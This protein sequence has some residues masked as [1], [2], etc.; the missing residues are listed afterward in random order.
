M[1]KHQKWL[2]AALL[3]VLTL[4]LTT[5]ALA[6]GGHHGGRHGCHSYSTPAC[7]VTACVYADE[8]GDGICDYFGDHRACVDADGDG[9]CDWRCEGYADA[10]GDGLCD[11]CDR[12]HVRENCGRGRHGCRRW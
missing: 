10:D 7:T 8:D 2:V 6:H 5:T 3:V 12:A 9:V 4:A 1:K 11:H